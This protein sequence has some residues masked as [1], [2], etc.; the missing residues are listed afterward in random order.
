MASPLVGT[1]T[2]ITFGTSGFSAN[3]MSVDGPGITREAIET[4]HMGTTTAKTFIPA[5][6]ID[7]GEM[8]FTMQFDGALDPPT[9]AAAETIT[10]DWGGA[11]TGEKWTFSGFMT[12]FNPSSPLEELMTASA[13]LKVTGD[14][15]VA[16][17]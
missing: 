7:G 10:I 4:T 12:G 5:D 9:D 6:L 13:T 11:G 14:V 16:V 8:S 15:T 1:G 3:I 17:V 2:T